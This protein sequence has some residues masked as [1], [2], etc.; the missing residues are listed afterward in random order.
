M[1][2]R[3]SIH[4]GAVVD[5]GLETFQ[6]PDSNEMTLEIV[7][8]PG[9]AAVVALDATDRVCLVRQYRHA[10]GGWIV[11]LPAGKID[12]GEQ[13]AVTAKRELQEEA[14][15]LADTWQS[16]ERMISTPG[17]C[18][19]VIFLFLARDLTQGATEH[20]SGEF[21][22]VFWQPLSEAC[23]QARDGDIF[24]A[25]TVIGLLRAEAL[26]QADRA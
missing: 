12:R 8:H 13:P 6:T 11:E 7:R 5:L 20:E 16:L 10:A 26:I 1:T 14:G 9:G 2:E 3:K 15:L 22:E 23:R 17:F 19:E 24:D 21:I 25:K 18:D 4:V